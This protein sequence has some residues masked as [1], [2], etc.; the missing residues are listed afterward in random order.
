M[1]VAAGIMLSAGLTY[2]ALGDSYTIGEGVEGSARF[3][4]QLVEKLHSQARVTLAQPQI[5]ATTGWTTADLLKALEAPSAPKGTFGFVTLLIGV[6][7]Q[8]QGKG[9]QEYRTEFARL[10]ERSVAFAA[11]HTDRVIVVS[12]PDWGVTPFAG[13]SGRDKT[14]I[15]REIDAF[16]AVKKEETLKRGIHFVDVTGISRRAEKESDLLAAD[17]LHPSGKMYALWADAVFQ[18]VMKRFPSKEFLK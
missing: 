5:V 3:P 2:L 17:G 7:N 14:K 9:L 12:I 18:V 10:L 8:Y 13:S 16:N 11:G 1:G 4:V 6:N 15:A